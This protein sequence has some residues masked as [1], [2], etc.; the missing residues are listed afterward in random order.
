MQLDLAALQGFLRGRI[1]LIFEHD[2]R[3]YV[4]DWKSNHLGDRAEDYAPAAL[5]VAM[6]QHGYEL[7]ALIYLLALHRFLIQRL[8]ARYDPER[9][10]G[11]AFYLFVRGVRRSWPQAGIW[12]WRPDIAWLERLSA[13]LAGGDRA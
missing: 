5:A 8:G 4:L 11:G 3:W 13:L 2:G 6:R 9:Q 12:H 1:D 7:Q 10:L